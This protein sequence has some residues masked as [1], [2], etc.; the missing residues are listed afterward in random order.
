MWAPEA[1]GRRR[2]RLGKA[3]VAGAPA[4]TS[5]SALV[6]RGAGD[7]LSL[8]IRAATNRAAGRD[9]QREVWQVSIGTSNHSPIVPIA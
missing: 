9:T 8:V 7:M 6:R 3:L 1:E 4:R 2:D 5:W